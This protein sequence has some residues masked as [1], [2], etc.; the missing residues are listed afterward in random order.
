MGST[1]VYH[2]PSVLIPVS[3]LVGMA[4]MAGIDIAGIDQAFNF[5]EL[6]LPSFFAICATFGTTMY[7]LLS[8]RVKLDAAEAS[9]MASFAVIWYWLAKART[10][11]MQR[12]SI[13]MKRAVIAAHRL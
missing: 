13:V 4:G 11:S 8:L 6:P 10:C 1:L 5:V 3:L 2:E 12:R 7:D 9:N